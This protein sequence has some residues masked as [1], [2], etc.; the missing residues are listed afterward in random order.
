VRCQREPRAL[1]P[2]QTNENP[3]VCIRQRKSLA[4]G[5][6]SNLCCQLAG[7]WTSEQGVVEGC[8]SPQ[9]LPLSRLLLALCQ[10]RSGT[11][12]SPSAT[13]GHAPPSSAA[14]SPAASRPGPDGR[15]VSRVLLRVAGMPW[16]RPGSWAA[17]PMAGQSLRHGHSL[18]Q[19]L[20]IQY[21][22]KTHPSERL[23]QP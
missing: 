23:G 21:S 8:G 16:R 15:V 4:V 13:S 12:S 3:G 18:S 11:W 1:R 7:L 2:V 19:Q 5:I 14:Q 20:E 9:R 6:P 10:Q 17:A 22:D